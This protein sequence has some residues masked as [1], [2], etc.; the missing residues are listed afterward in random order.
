M[1]RSSKMTKQINKFIK[2]VLIKNNAGVKQKWKA[3]F[4]FCL[5]VSFLLHKLCC[6]S[7]RAGETVIASKHLVRGSKCLRTGRWASRRDQE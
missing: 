5:K 3:V 1:R 2:I 4:F 7:L 6:V